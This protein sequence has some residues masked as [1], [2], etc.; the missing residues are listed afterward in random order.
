MRHVI[1]A[2]LILTFAM[3]C[4]EQPPVEA[5]ASHPE[6]A[7]ENAVVPQAGK[8]MLPAYKLPG[9]MRPL[10]A[11][12]YDDWRDAHPELYA[13]TEAPTVAVRPVA[14]YEDAGRL[15]ITISTWGLP[16]GIRQNFVDIVKA[17][18][19][20]V[21]VY[22]IHDGASVKSSFTSA[23]SSAG[24]T[25]N[26]V[27]WVNMSLDSIWTRD[28]GPTPITSLSGKVGM[29]DNRY[30]HQRIYDDAIPTKMGSL[31]NTSVFRSP[32]DFEGGNFMADTA[33]NCFC[34]EGVLMYNGVSESQ[35]KGYFEDYYGCTSFHIMKTLANEGTTHIDMQM[36]LVSDETVL[37]G[38]YGANQDYQNYLVTNQNAAYFEGLGYKV[39]RMPMPS[40]S[41]G[42]FRTFINSLFVNGV[43]MVPVYSIDKTKEAQALAIW[44][45]VMPTWQHVPMNSDDVIQWAGA[46][47]CITMTT[48]AGSFSKMQTDPEYACNG[49][50]DCYPGSG[51]SGCDGL[52][53]EGCCD[54]NLLKYCE[55]NQLKTI[56]CGNNP[57]CGWK[58]DAGFYDCSTNGA[59]DPSGQFP[60]NC[61]G[62][63]VPACGG[64]ECGTDGCG[65][66][67][68]NCSG[69]ETCQ[70]GQ[71]VPQADGCD[72]LTYEGCCDGNT[73][74]YCDNN[75]IATV[76]C[77]NN[78]KCGWHTQNKFYDCGT[79]GGVDPSGSFPKDCGGV[80]VPACN[81]KECGADGCGGT[82]G[83]CAAGEACQAGQCTGGC[84]P[85]CAG[86]EC[87]GDGCG[88]S[89]G[90]CNANE[91]C[92]TDKC[93][94]ACT[95]SCAG[96]ECGDNGC[97]G[98]CGTCGAG[99]LC[100]AGKCNAVED[101]CLGISWAGCCENS[102]LHWC[103]NNA[104]QSLECEASGCGWNG[105]NDYYDCNQSGADPSG[106]N[107]LDCPGGQ[108]IPN[109][110]GKV[111]GD[112]GCGGS[113]GTCGVGQ[114]C[115]AGICI[116]ESGCGD[117]TY[118]GSC[119]GQTLVWCE[120]DQVNSADCSAL[121]G[122]YKC[123][124]WADGDG[125]Y[126]VEKD[127]CV[128]DCA[129]MA[130]GDDGCGGTC[131]SCP[132]EENCQNGTCIPG[133]CEPDCVGKACGADGCGG[134]CGTC[135]D[136][137]YCK[138][139]HCADEC[140]PD[141]AGFECGADGCGGSCGVCPAGFSCEASVCVQGCTPH[142]TGK[143]CGDDSC[144]G[145][146]GSCPA[147]NVCQ[148]GKCSPDCVPACDNLEC[149]SDGCGGSCGSCPKDYTCD[150][151]SCTAAPN[152]CGNVTSV[153]QCDGDVLNKCI[154]SQVVSINCADTG[155][156]C[157][158]VP[159][160]GVFDCVADCIPNCGGKVCGGDGC[161]G[162]CGTCL[163]G[164]SCEDGQCLLDDVP[165][166]PAC[167][168]LECGEDG[169]GGSCGGC[170]EGHSCTAGICG[171]ETPVV[172][173]DIIG[174]SVVEEDT[175]STGGGSKSGGC[176]ATTTGGPSSA[177]LLLLL[178]IALVVVRRTSMA[179]R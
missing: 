68:G 79:N 39:V 62:D 164:E 43:N 32:L 122:N 177:L 168:G 136:G 37:V 170:A 138:S 18:K 49:D 130:C 133:P 54:G 174:D 179:C 128:P 5:V 29:V 66:S 146:C 27:T 38:E 101:P 165:C 140:L 55:N 172:G 106:S 147:G 167:E 47:H 121:D 2:F 155:K 42:A 48:V 85:N 59:A 152:G 95:P 141:C 14:E 166:T 24:V 51:T 77:T 58:A 154:S 8:A 89:C 124:F 93:V 113:C 173:A 67:C 110:A 151:G 94:P 23:L 162:T 17:G 98:S 26:A 34:S 149:G 4:D 163:K 7:A 88:G 71:C 52:G 156:V 127:A 144:G 142:C 9:D 145:F 114:T 80:C 22:V 134:V 135:P 35:L 87:G 97:G 104:V 36:K 153:G 40:N 65:G 131:G 30:Y 116:G 53:Y 20:V 84:A 129:G 120:N 44:K 159:N 115:L 82:C 108:C 137:S 25:S 125:F 31:W 160:A 157:S 150:N 86:K 33:G 143:E 83:T 96:K 13:I 109:C 92:Q 10:K 16:A 81:G 107:P 6:L 158:F 19:N 63:C 60:K 45:E 61:G 91:S 57:Q 72:G 102:T 50:W 64:K 123:E 56:N 74:K 76:D 105:A 112:D 69:N 126:C 1:A 175:G 103:E 148:S 75:Q 139:G 11:D 15:M 169:C 100:Q 3:G 161:D 132:A 111:C 99:E 119:D 21:D 73:L 70:A 78:Q 176:T 46:I 117:V 28:Y 90:S 171:E 41:D 118:A 178:A 12:Q